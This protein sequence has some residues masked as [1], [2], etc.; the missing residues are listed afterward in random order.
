VNDA[1]ARVKLDGKAINLAQLAQE[2]GAPLTGSAAEV[3]V[4]DARSSVTAEELRVAVG[5][6][7]PAEPVDHDAEFRQAVEAATTIAGLKAA[8]L[9]SKGPGAEPRRPA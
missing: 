9:G 3:V 7:V 5:A 4:A 6:H 1:R 8:L 2:V